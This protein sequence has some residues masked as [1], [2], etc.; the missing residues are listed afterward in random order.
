MTVKDEVKRIKAILED[1]EV[2]E[3]RVKHLEPII[4]QTAWMRMKLEDA[5]ETIADS[6]VVIPYD[7]GGGQT[8]I[9]I[10]PLFDGYER[11]WKSY[12]AGMDRISAALPKE[13]AIELA[14]EAEKPKTML[15]LIREKHKKE[16]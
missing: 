10:N 9:R 12:L 5:M 1:A 8:G 11:L 13:K 4:E 7:N 6:Q 2:S 14:E 3:A 16:A 15:E